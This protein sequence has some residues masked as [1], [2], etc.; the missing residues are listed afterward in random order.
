MDLHGQAAALSTAQWIHFRWVG[1]VII[2]LESSQSSL[3]LC[4]LLQFLQNQRAKERTS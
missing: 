3:A 2:R 4:L 1:G